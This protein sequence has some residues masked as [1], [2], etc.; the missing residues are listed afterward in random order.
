M[1]DVAK[2]AAE[3]R[4]KLKCFV[5]VTIDLN[6]YYN[7]DSEEVVYSIYRQDEDLGYHNLKSVEEVIGR[8]YMIANGISDEGM[9]IEEGE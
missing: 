2:K 5:S 7:P 3:Y 4:D 6:G 8:L 9:I 1:Q